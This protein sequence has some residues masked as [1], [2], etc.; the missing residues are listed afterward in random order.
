LITEVWS[1]PTFEPHAT[2]PI[3]TCGE[4]LRQIPSAINNGDPFQLWV[5]DQPEGKGKKLLTLTVSAE[6]G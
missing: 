6:N 1:F 3:R 2:K 5:T 4:M